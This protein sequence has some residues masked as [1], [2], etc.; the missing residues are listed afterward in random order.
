MKPVLLA[1]ALCAR[2]GADLVRLGIYMTEITACCFPTR[3]F[4]L[5]ARA[6]FLNCLRL[7][8]TQWPRAAPDLAGVQPR[9]M[10]GYFMGNRLRTRRMGRIVKKSGGEP[11]RESAR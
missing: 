9:I 10:L 7:L 6:I 8:R 11:R 4:L 1:C 3:P 5:F 2:R